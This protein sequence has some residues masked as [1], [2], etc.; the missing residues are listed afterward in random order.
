MI[1]K[2][3]ISAAAAAAAFTAL[4]SAAQAQYHN[5]YYDRGGY[6]QRY[7]GQRYAPRYSQN[8][9]YG[10]NRYYGRNDRSY[11]NGGRRC[12]GT[13]G[14]IVGGAAGALLGRTLDGGRS[15]TTGTIAGGVVGALLGRQV[16]KSAC[17]R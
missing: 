3:T 14:T 5:G 7:Y 6:E 13:T 4:P 11:Y 10:Q 8:Q 15:R 9:Y 17:R 2:L 16:G 1:K 12:S